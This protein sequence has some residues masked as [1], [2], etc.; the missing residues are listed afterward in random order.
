[1]AGLTQSAVVKLILEH[2]GGSKI[3]GAGPG[4][5]VGS[6]EV[7]VKS[8]AI[9]GVIS[10]LQALGKDISS[11]R[12]QILQNPQLVA[13]TAAT[14][15][16]QSLASTVASIPGLL[17]AQTA[18]LTAAVTGVLTAA[19]NFALHTG[20]L[21]GVV[22]VD[23]FANLDTGTTKLSGI[24]TG[25]TKNTV[26]YSTTAPASPTAGDFWTNT[27]SMPFVH[28]IYTGAAWQVVSSYVTNTQHITDGA[29]LGS[30]AIWSGVT[31]TGKAA[32]NATVGAT[33]GSN[34]TG[35]PTNLSALGGTEGILN[36][37]VT[38][39]ANGSLGGAGT[40]NVLLGAGG[41]GYLG[42]L[43]ATYG[44][45][46]NANITGTPI[47]LTD[48]RVSA[49]LNSSGGIDFSAGFHSNKSLANVD[50]SQNTKL[51]GV[52]TGATKNTVTYSNTAPTSPTA[53]DFW[54]NTASMPF[55]H[56][57]YTGTVWQ[58]VS[59]YVTNTQHIT[60]G[61]NLGATALWGGVTGTGKAADYAT[62][63]AVWGT[64]LTGRPT[65]LT[66]GRIASGLN[67]S[68]G[69]DF[70]LGAHTNKSLANIDGTA[71][72]KL[73]GI[74]TGATK[75][76]VTYSTTAPI[77]PTAGDFWTNTTSMPFVHQVYTGAAWQVVSSYVTNTQHITDGANLGSTA[78]W[79]GV[80]SRPAELTD[81]RITSGL[82]SAGDIIR[83]IPTSIRN[84]SNLLG[85]TGGAIYN[86]HLTATSNIISYSTVA[87]GSPA[88]G[89]VWVDTS[90][91][92]NLTKLYVAGA[93]QIGANYSSNTNQLTD[94]ANLGSTATW[95]GVTG[96]GK[97]ADNATVGATWGTNLTG[98]PTELTDGRITSGLN[99]S[100]GIDFT[101]GA[102]TNKSLANVDG[103]ASTKL[104]GI[105]TGATA[106]VPRGIWSSSSVVYV[107]NDMVYYNNTLYICIL[108]YTSSVAN[109]AADPTHWTKYGHASLDTLLDGAT[110]ARTL[111]SQ[112]SSG[113]HKLTVPTSGIQLG[114]QRNLP[115]I[116]TQNLH[117]LYNGAISYS[118]TTTTATISVAAGSS[119]IGTA[120]ISY[121]ACSV[122][123]TGTA[124][125]AVN[126]FLY[127]DDATYAGGSQTLVATTTPTVIYQNDG[128]VYV[129]SVTVNY[130][131]TGTT[132]GTGSG[133]GGGCVTVDTV[134][135]THDHAADVVVGD[136]L[137][138]ANPIT[139]VERKGIV[140]C[141]QVK[142]AEC[143]RLHTVSGIEL[144][145]SVS[146]PIAIAD[147]SLVLAPDLLDHI[148]PVCDFG[149]Y[150]YEKVIKVEPLGIKQ[151]VH[152]TCENDLFLAGRLQGRYILHHNLK[153]IAP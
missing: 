135:P 132:A 92:P 48:G 150:R 113:V 69:I 149:E 122:G 36:T 91:S 38:I 148:I 88:N 87:P 28:Q 66:D 67:S 25:A 139:F 89:D 42:D 6:Q 119:Y 110:Y 130:P 30:T 105:A 111:A 40:G 153:P 61:A 99:A 83:S 13:I 121:N 24:A 18:Q 125:T 152:I 79:T 145:C 20:I 95:T 84:S 14:A 3:A 98:R 108:G 35:R 141:V 96:A 68:G 50:P 143:V 140:S 8:P 15:K 53:G 52:D 65:E 77:S 94:G 11:I 75:N 116:A 109:P 115:G 133:G 136:Q 128:R 9:S 51:I 29:N 46:W 144:D 49:G 55:V 39:N 27:T 93:W 19:D 63:G 138:I 101:L 78:I 12:S 70:T 151:I 47:S 120:S 26:T 23:P 137:I 124:G 112:L 5:V 146:A 22:P 131:A 45:A 32:D 102:H 118:A 10:K 142:F 71:S 2:I 126:Y 21:S 74:A 7:I 90:V 64:N 73:G 104:S 129:G 62:V 107:V 57:V 106:N 114:D 81:G 123:T 58:V 86:G 41:L 17:P 4:V 43:N 60:D 59:S 44:A 33:W 134:L 82:S 147:G 117:Y 31:G 100:G 103:T 34:L 37:L 56:Q 54:T 16:I 72:T 127:F 80:S 1:M 76:I 97:A 85:F